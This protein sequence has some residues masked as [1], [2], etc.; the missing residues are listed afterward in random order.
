MQI[1]LMEK[2]A[3]LGNLGDLLKVKDGYARNFLIPTG[4]ARRATPAALQEF[5]AKRAELEQAAAAKLADAQA[6][7]E[8]LAGVVVRIERKA[9]VDGRLFGSVTNFDIADGLRAQGFEIEKSA[10][11]MPG[12][13]LK[14]IGETP[15][16]V[17]LHG[18][19]LATITVA[20]VIEQ[21]KI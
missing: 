13:P 16:E 3:N 1:I 7:A 9:G 21:A 11:R 10:V 20:V 5:E 2:V 18:D 15:L 19:V 14:T 17:A 8:K 12:G 6:Y 4:K